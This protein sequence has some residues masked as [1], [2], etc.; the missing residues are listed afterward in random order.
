MENTIQKVESTL[1]FKN[2][3]FN[4]TG[5]VILRASVLVRKLTCFTKFDYE[6]YARST[7]RTMGLKQKNKKTTDNIKHNIL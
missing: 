5:H 4:L 3:S 6:L 1:I 2:R 7:T